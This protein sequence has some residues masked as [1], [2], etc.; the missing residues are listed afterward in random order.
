MYSQI[1]SFGAT[2]QREYICTFFSVIFFCTFGKMNIY[3]WNLSSMHFKFSLLYN[4]SS[5]LAKN[6]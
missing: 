6:N 2:L 5:N 1:V 3:L 4:V